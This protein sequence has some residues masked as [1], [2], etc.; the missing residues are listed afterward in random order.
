MKSVGA[1]GSAWSCRVAHT[2]RAAGVE[3]WD[4]G[5]KTQDLKRDVRQQEKYVK[6]A[7]SEIRYDEKTAKMLN[8]RRNIQIRKK[9]DEIC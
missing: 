8:L 3:A 6:N 4:R 1:R 7:V 5:W 2:F 9:I